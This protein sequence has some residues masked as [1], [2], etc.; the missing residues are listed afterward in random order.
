MIYETPELSIEV[1]SS[2]YSGNYRDRPILENYSSFQS[3]FVCLHPFLKIKADCLD[4]IKFETG[5][6][7]TK[8]AIEG[9]CDPLSWTELIRLTGIRDIKS[10]DRALAFYHRA[11]RFAERSEYTK[12]IRL[13]EQERADL[14]MPQ[15]DEL[16]EILENKLLQ[17]LSL[18]GY[19]SVFIYS[20]TDPKRHSYTIESLL[21]KLT[22]LPSHV[23]IE[24]PDSQILI[25]QD[26]DQRFS[27]ILGN[28]S[29]LTDMAESLDLD[30]FFCD[31]YTP[32]SWSYYEIPEIER[33]DWNEDMGYKV[34]HD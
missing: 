27:Y 2:L 9:Y 19:T 12:L 18:L 20:D 16:A 13:I 21:L 8:A 33:M 5:N 28:Q 4:K 29:I 31:Q 34:S 24:T 25:A 10:L 7:P 11:Y 6:W 15:V 1:K 17:K 22:G 14:I 26:F 32:E 30:G 23:R 3:C